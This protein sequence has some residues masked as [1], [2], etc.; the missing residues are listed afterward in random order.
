MVT[1]LLKN[2]AEKLT[3]EGD[4]ADTYSQM[5]S[6][7]ESAVSIFTYI[8]SLATSLL[9]NEYL[10]LIVVLTPGLAADWIASSTENNRPRL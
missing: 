1:N 4:C 2:V 5:L 10:S 6:I 7:F 9:K 3:Y 8:L